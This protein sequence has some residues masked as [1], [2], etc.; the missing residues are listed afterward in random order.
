[1]MKK[2]ALLYVIV[3]LL[4]PCNVF[5]QLL[6]SFS[7]GDFTSSL[8]WTGDT[9]DWEIATNSTCSSNVSDSYTLHI[10]A[11]VSET[12]SKYLSVQRTSSWGTEQSWGFWIG[13]RSGSAP[14]GSNQSCV[15]LYANESDL[16]SSTVDGYRIVL[17]QSGADYIVLQKVTNG[18]GTDLLQSN[19]AIP[20]GI[21]DYGI[22][23]RI[24]R[25]SSS[26]WNIYTSAIPQNN[27]EGAVATDIPSSVNT[28]VSQGSIT[29]NTYTNFSNGFLG[30]VANYTSSGTS[31][32]EFDQF[33]FATSATAPL[34]VG[35][36]DF[37][38]DYS[39]GKIQLNWRT[40]TEVNNFGFEVERVIEENANANSQQW[41]KIE[42]VKGKGNSNSPNVYS[43]EDKISRSGVYKYRLKQLDFDGNYN[44]SEEIEVYIPFPGEVILNQNYPNPFNPTT[45]ISFALPRTEFVSLKVYDVLGREVETLLSD[46]ITPGKYDIK[47]DGSGL[48]SGFYFYKIEGEDFSIVKKM[49]LVK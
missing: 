30:V 29:D 24:T 34:P 48:N 49:V 32:A 33:Y 35:L 18:S 9:G 45:K 16:N 25:N 46:K 44:Y 43:F 40:E 23:I 14:S 26:N 19:D 13:R 11:I 1:M 41:T 10:N 20:T 38:G 42:F 7:D 37:N 15:W 22:L 17:G 6:D 47:F 5:P 3:S 12:S 28:N 36:S 8:A 2:L 4:S 27:G 31:G 21:D 39:N